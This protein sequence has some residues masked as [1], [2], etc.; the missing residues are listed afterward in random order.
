MSSVALAVLRRDWEIERTYRLRLLVMFISTLGFAVGLFFVGRLITDPAALGDY[1]GGYFDFAIVGLAVTTFA[2]VGLQAFSTSLV[3]E[4][5]TGTIDLLLASP[6]PRRGLLF[7]QFLLPFGIALIEFVALLGL[8]VG[9]FGSGLPSGGIL[10]C[11]PILALTTATFA[12]VGIVGAAVLMIAKRGDALSGPFL[13]VTL[14]LSGAVY[15]LDVLPAG[16]RVL[17]LF[18]PA[19][20]AIKAARELL[21]GGGSIVDVLPEIAVLIG[22]VVV[23]L[24]LSLMA[25][26]RCLRYARRQGLLGAY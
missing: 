15:P 7:G 2:A 16:L 17:S 13:Q 19:T 8:G 22:F 12:A 14:L 1:E 26:G 18:I 6:A 24:P 10:L 5:S 11:I 23:M 25:F 20:W 9:V 21:L 3:N 4:Q